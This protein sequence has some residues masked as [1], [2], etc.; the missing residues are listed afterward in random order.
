MKLVNKYVQIFL[1]QH[2]SL[3]FVAGSR[4]LIH[5]LFI[6]YREY[7]RADGTQI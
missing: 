4:L 3:T 7:F 2:R 5:K 6:E 1:I